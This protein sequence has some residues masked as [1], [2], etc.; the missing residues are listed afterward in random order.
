M[1]LC[2]ENEISKNILRSSLVSP[3]IFH[4][5]HEHFIDDFFRIFNSLKAQHFN[6]F[7]LL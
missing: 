7:E 4:D 6:R 1:F 2:F 5:Y 3:N